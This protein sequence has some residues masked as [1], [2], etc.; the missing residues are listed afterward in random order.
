MA[1]KK[2]MERV[3][4]HSYHEKH[5]RQVFIKQ[6]RKFKGHREECKYWNKQPRDIELEN[7]RT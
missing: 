4:K 2:K 6:K 7:T 3:I 5:H 1:R